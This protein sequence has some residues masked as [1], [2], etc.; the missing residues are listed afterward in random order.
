V[1]SA[2]VIN[3]GTLHEGEQAAQA[4]VSLDQKLAIGERLR[5]IASHPTEETA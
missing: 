2:P 3:D 4:N 1:A 5:G